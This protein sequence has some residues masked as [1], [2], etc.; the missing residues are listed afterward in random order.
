VLAD[1]GR[2]ISLSEVRELAK[3]FASEIG[4]E[5]VGFECPPELVDQQLA[6]SPEALEVL[7]RELLQ[8]AVKFH[9]AKD[10]AIAITITIADSGW[11]RVAFADDGRT[12]TPAEI[13]RAWRPYYQGGKCNTG[14]TPGMGLGLATVSAIIW[15]CGGTCKLRNR[16]SGP[17]VVVEVTLPTN[18]P[19]LEDGSQFFPT[20][21]QRQEINDVY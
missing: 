10:P 13:D 8:N 7:F 2:E 21:P 18:S 4:I 16:E 20:S 17:G 14:Q 5:R 9:P 15:D 19:P 3:Q 12:L 6:I 1:R 11:V